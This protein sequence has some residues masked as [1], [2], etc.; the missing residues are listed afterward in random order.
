M[1]KYVTAQATSRNK[2]ALRMYNMSDILMEHLCKLMLHNKDRQN[3]VN[4]WIESVSSRLSRASRYDTKSS[5]DED[6][7]EMSLFASF[8]V[9]AMDAEAILED[10]NDELVA[11]GYPHVNE[12]DIH[13]VSSNFY[14]ACSYIMSECV[15]LFM[16]KNHDRDMKYF[17]N[18]I[19]KAFSD[20]GVDL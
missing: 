20:N 13:T 17:N 3:D 16:S 5:V 1:F 12:K 9:S 18:M 14:E 2:L 10:W 4:G 11:D 6:F 15:A 7:Y 8:P 19:R